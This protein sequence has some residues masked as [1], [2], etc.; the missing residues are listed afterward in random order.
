MGG[1]GE[2]D[3]LVTTAANS[4]LVTASRARSELPAAGAANSDGW[5]RSARAVRNSP[6]VTRSM[7]TGGSRTRTASGL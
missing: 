6:R 5:S 4:D 7:P 3:L 2:H 1:G